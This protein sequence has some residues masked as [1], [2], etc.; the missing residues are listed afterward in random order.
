MRQAVILVGG[1][2]VL[3]VFK[4]YPNPE[5]GISGLFSKR[6]K[7]NANDSQALRYSSSPGR[8][9]GRSVFR[10][11]SSCTGKLYLPKTFRCS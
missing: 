3:W 1:A 7:S 9:S 2:W 5:G 11:S 4:P 10:R 6:T 8:L